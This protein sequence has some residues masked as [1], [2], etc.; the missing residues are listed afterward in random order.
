V[1]LP[2][3]SHDWYVS[4][5]CSVKKRSAFRNEDTL[6]VNREV[7]GE[8]NGACRKVHNPTLRWRSDSDAGVN[9]TRLV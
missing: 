5:H 2:A 4:G 6:F 9:R 8:M 3:A 1:H 7:R